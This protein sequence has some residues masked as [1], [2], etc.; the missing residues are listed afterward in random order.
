MGFMDRAKRAFGMSSGANAP[1]ALEA[2]REEPGTRFHIPNPSR[3]MTTV[4][5]VEDKPNVVRV[6]FDPRFYAMHEE[7]IRSVREK[8]ATSMRV[9]HSISHAIEEDNRWRA[10]MRQGIAF[11]PAPP[12]SD[13]AGI[14]MRIAREDLD[15][16][17]VDL[18]PIIDRA[19][20]IDTQEQYEQL[21]AIAASAQG[22]TIQVDVRTLG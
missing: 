15:G 22:K 21:A 19:K 8:Y 2:A 16:F 4:L 14:D 6:M 5:D 1:E 13:Y 20:E 3:D 11:T 17:M 12:G 18:Q 10:A 9:F 7:A